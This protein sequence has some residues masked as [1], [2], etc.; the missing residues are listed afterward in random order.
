MEARSIRL[1][2]GRKHSP[3]YLIG[4][5]LSGYASRNSSV[6]RTLPPRTGAGC[7]PLSYSTWPLPQGGSRVIDTVLSGPTTPEMVD[8]FRHTSTISG[9]E[10]LAVT[11]AIYQLRFRL[12]GRSV[13]VFV[14]NNAVT[15]SIV[16]GQTP[17]QPAHSFISGMWAIA[18]S[19]SI[20]LWF[21]RAPSALNI[22]D[23]PTWFK[24]PGYPIAKSTGFLPLQQWVNFTN[25]IFY[26]C[27]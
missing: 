12:L 15:G 23:L 3:C 18:A 16:K 14:D 8:L 20:S 4:L 26:P 25:R 22:A 6:T 1:N 5:F 13:I 10:L 24:I 2:G 21:E 9:L 11:M 7:L 17:G 19:L 27:F